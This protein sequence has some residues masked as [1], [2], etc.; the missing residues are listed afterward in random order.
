MSQNTKL[1]HGIGTLAWLTML[2]KVIRLVILMVTAR[3]LTPE[4]FGIFAAFTMVLGF[5]YLSAEMGII[6]T[7]IQRP[8][9]NSSHLGSSIILS[10]FFCATTILCLIYGSNYISEYIGIKEIALPLKISAGM[11]IILAFSNVCSS[12]IQRNGEILYIGKVQAIGTVIGSVF[13]TM[14]LLYLEIGYWSI[15]VG[16]W[17]SEIIP[18]L[19]ILLKGWKIITIEIIKISTVFKFV[20]KK[21]S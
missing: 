12:I 10:I 8:V 20:F 9:I 14:P 3:Y 2:S 18:I 19:L 7:L 21:G 4:D 15:I 16:L 11:F 17:V 1:L 6:R 13:V 5:A